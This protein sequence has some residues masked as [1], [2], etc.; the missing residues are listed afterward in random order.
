MWRIAPK[1][2]ACELVVA[3]RNPRGHEHYREVLRHHFSA[4]HIVIE[5]RLLT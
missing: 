3:A 5:E 1:A 4:K 2:I